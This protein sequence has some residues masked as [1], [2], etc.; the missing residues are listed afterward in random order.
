MVSG[1]GIVSEHR[2]SEMNERTI[3]SLTLVSARLTDRS[4][5]LL[6]E[7][8]WSVV[9]GGGFDVS[10]RFKEKQQLWPWSSSGGTCMIGEVV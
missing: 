3:I 1:K 4:T 2:C 10:K 7:Y 9:R 5:G 6:V 8:V